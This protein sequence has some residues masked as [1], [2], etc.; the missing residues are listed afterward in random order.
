MLHQLHHPFTP[1]TLMR[2]GAKGP[3]ANNG[4]AGCFL[5]TGERRTVVTRFATNNAINA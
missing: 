1:A 5:D 3:L 2:G 4:A